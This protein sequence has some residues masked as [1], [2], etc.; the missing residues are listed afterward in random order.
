MSFLDTTQGQAFIDV[1]TERYRADKVI[2]VSPLTTV[3]ND[4]ITDIVKSLKHKGETVDVERKAVTRYLRVFELVI[5]KNAINLD[6]F[7]S[8][9]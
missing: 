3:R 4:D 8:V 5:Q 9:A 6:K 7:K 1:A 2:H